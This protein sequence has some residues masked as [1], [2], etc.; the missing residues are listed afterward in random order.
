MAARQTTAP[1]PEP[2][3]DASP[4]ARKSAG[5]RRD[6]IV[7]AAIGHFA[8]GGYAGTST[9]A[10]ARDAG[11]SQPYL[12]RLFG[13]KRDLFLACQEACH[14]RV[15][16]TFRRAAE[17]R[18]PEERLEAMGHAY[19]GLLEDRTMLLFQMQGYAA[20]AD[21]VIRGR[22]RESYG[23]LIK[24][25]R[26]LSGAS[27]EELWRFF[28]NGMLLNVIAALDL[29]AVTGQDDWAALWTDA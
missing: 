26:R 11:I 21:E 22:V 20:G 24:E 3:A 12:F 17:G 29:P 8:V 16:D 19:V 10:I 14:Q 15:L 9:E 5:E 27:A 6:E 7:A 1:Q 13:T 4:R 23:G 25:V 2:A 18:E 28:G